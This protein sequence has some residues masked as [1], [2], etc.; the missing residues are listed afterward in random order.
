MQSA[1]LASRNDAVAID[2]IGLIEPGV[3]ASPNIIVTVTAIDRTV[4]ASLTRLVVLAGIVVF[5][6]AMRWY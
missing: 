1:S 6:L 3:L 5:I 4:T 2:F